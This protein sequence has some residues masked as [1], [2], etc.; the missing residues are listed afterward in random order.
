MWRFTTTG[1]FFHQFTLREEGEDEWG[2]THGIDERF[3]SFENTIYQ[4]TEVAEFVGRLVTTVDYAPA[5]SLEIELH[6]MLNRQ[7][8]SGPDIC[9]RGSPVSRVDPIRINP[10]LEPLRLLADARNVAIEFATAVFQLFAVETNDVVIRGV[11]DKILA[12]A[13]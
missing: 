8:V 10:S 3:L 6:G 13:G 1:Q 7:L 2:R 4:L 9:L 12:P 11:Q 5:L